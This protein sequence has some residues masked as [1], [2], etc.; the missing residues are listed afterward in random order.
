MKTGAYFAIAAAVL[1]LPLWF[2]LSLIIAG[3]FHEWCHYLTLRLLGIRVYRISI[4][5]F[6]ASM[7]TEAMEPG[8]ELVCV[9]AGPLGSLMLVTLFRW[10][11]G[12]AL[13]GLI[14]GLCNLLPIYPMDGGRVLRSLLGVFKISR[15]DRILHGVEWMVSLGI[16]ALGFWMQLRWDLGWGMALAGVVLV[17]RIIRRKTPCNK[18]RFGVQ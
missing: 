7:E 2:L 16:L 8:R 18:G 12:I 15:G 6:G 3:A 14:Q 5:P 11:P 10:L 13:C 17:L 9:L 4:G 1:I